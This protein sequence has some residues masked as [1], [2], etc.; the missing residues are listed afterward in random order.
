[1]ENL[2]LSASALGTGSP[3][4]SERLSCQIYITGLLF[5]YIVCKPALGLCQALTRF[6]LLIHR[7]YQS[8]KLLYSFGIFFTYALQ[9]YVPA[10][11]I[12]PCARSRVPERWA[13][14]VDLLLR[15]FLVCV[16]CK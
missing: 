2:T 16:T 9:F 13:L 15:T 14:A 5:V 12:I 6:P 11:I 8:V 7:M 4:F 10:E 3:G 1:M